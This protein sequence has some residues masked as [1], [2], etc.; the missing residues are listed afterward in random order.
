[1]GPRFLR[2]SHPHLSPPPLE[3]GAQ[4]KCRLSD[5]ALGQIAPLQNWKYS[6]AVTVGAD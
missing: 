6:P 5:A 2:Y 4:G 1:M 3:I